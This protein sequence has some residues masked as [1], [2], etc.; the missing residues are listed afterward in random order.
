MSQESADTE[1]YQR[2]IADCGHALDLDLQDGFTY[3]IRGTTYSML[4]DYQHAIE[5]LNLAIKL[6]LN[7]AS[8]Y[9]NQGTVY[10]DLKDY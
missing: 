5:D 1:D 4:N 10:Y 7:R 2:V 3:S 6:E 8:S 9:F